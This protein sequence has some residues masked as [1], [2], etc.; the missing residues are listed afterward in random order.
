MAHT[1]GSNTPIADE[2]MMLAMDPEISSMFVGE[3]LDHLG[4]IEGLVLQL[5][6]TPG[7]VKL[8]NDVFRPFHTI[9]GNAGA[10]GVTSIQEVAHRVENLL[11]LARS[12]K[13]HIGPAEIDVVLR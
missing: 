8:L 7:D 5:E 11:D 12:G 10:L 13:H 2:L 9:K 6:T 4:T 3:A 1:D